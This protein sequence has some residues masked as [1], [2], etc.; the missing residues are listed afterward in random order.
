MVMLNESDIQ[1]REVL[2]WKGIHLFH[3]TGSTC[4][5]KTRIFLRLKEIPWKSHH[6]NLARKE[7]LK[8]YFMGVN[9]RGLVPVL[10]H[11]GKVIIES[12]DI[13]MH[14]ERTFPEPNLL[15]PEHSDSISELLH[16]EDELHLD[17]RALTMRF[18]FPS[19]LTM[20]ARHDLENYERSG[21][22]TV[23]GVADERRRRELD[24]WGDMRRN[25][26][27]TDQQ[28]AKAFNRFKLALDK[29]EEKLKSH[30]YL[31][32]NALSLL[33]IAWYI[34][35]RR[36]QDAGYPIERLHPRFGVWLRDIHAR[37]AFRDEAPSGG[38]GAY[39]D[40]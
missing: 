12:N 20:R 24:F 16:E 29:Y 6:I 28:A 19:F 2:K 21:S 27:I 39:A 35:A 25:G 13:L 14:L 11:D 38:T 9:P 10:V 1:T 36:L 3:F 23:N 26:G 15:P 34:Y 7:Q 31:A 8:P 22:G 32:G 30:S 18:V 5:Q 40:P 37:K 17:I 33:D 4:S